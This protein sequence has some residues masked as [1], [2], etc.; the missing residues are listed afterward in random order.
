M[1]EIYIRDNQQDS[2]LALFNNYK[3]SWTELSKLIFLKK[4]HKSLGNYKEAL[5]YEEAGNRYADSITDMR[6]RAN[7]AALEHKF[8]YTQK[9]LE[10]YKARSVAHKRLITVIILVFVFALAIVL[11]GYIL[12]KKKKEIQEYMLFIE[13]LRLEKDS[14]A[15]NLLRLQEENNRERSELY[16]LL[17][18]RFA[19][20]QNM[21]NLSYQHLE[22]PSTFVSKVKKELSSESNIDVLLD[23][24]YKMVDRKNNG[25]LSAI[26]SDYAQLSDTDLKIISLYSEDF[27]AV[28]IAFLFNTTPQNIHTRRYRLVKKLNITVPIGNFVREYTKHSV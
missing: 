15:E 27:S 21:L 28:A 10:M 19:D 22:N 12:M 6:S 4:Y 7:L 2:A 8:D 25:A 11:A 3:K 5:F 18:R 23:D 9:E 24:L 26:R 1:A 14:I 13:Q 17:G 16:T 20:I